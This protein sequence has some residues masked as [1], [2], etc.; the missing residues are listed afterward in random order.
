MD[1]I[2]AGV[3]D[4]RHKGV[5]DGDHRHRRAV[6]Q[7]RLMDFAHDNPAI[8]HAAGDLHAFAAGTLAQIRNLHTINSAIE[9]DLTGQVNSEMAGGRYVGAVGGQVDYVR[10]GRLSPGGRSIFAMAS[11][12][13]DGK[14]SKI[15]ATSGRSR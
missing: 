13:P 14:H 3:V 10:G 8:A 6:R 12:T 9:I 15:V 1:L 5:D 4:N 2:E 7:P 11:A